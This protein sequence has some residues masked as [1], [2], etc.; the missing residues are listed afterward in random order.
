MLFDSFSNRALALQNRIVMAPMTRCRADHADA[1]PNALITGYYRQRAGAGLVIS[2]GVPVS[3]RARGYLNTP[4]LWNE[5]QAAGWQRVT[6]AVHAEGGTMFAQLW[7]CGRVAHAALHADGSAPAGPSNKPAATK[8][9]IPGPDGKPVAVASGQPQALSLQEI[10][11]VVAEFAHSAKLAMQAGF[12]GV[13]I[14]GAN[15]YLLDQF[16]CPAV[17]DRN[18]AYGGSLANRYRLLLEIVDAVAAEV[19]PQR[20]AV[21]QSPYGVNNGMV[22]DPEPLQTYP[23][24]AR[25]LSRRDI[26]FLHIYCQSADWI[27][28]PGHSMMPA[29]R[30][31]YHGAIIACGGFKTPAA[32]EAILAR[33]HA[34]LIAIGKPFISNPD[35]V[36]RLRQD[37][38]LAKWD[39]AAFYAGGA[40]GY[41]DYPA[42]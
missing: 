41:A 33:G 11:G 29:L 12:D 1:V 42:L 27:H 15:G 25:E 32:C 36:E 39:P 31:A 30:D 7:H 5:A 19:D 2:E 4:A 21:R 37:A 17:N 40:T 23:W 35:L 18:D 6:D 28:E 22:A 20:I 26:G 38:P 14:H 24:L 9:M 16:R 10:R 8:T 13:E 34:D 3:D